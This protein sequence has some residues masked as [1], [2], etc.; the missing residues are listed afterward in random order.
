MEIAIK[1]QS[2][3]PDDAIKKTFESFQQKADKKIKEL[4][5]WFN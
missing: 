5:N 4:G 1:S 3:K 2:S